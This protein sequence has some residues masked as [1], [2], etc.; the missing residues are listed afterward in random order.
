MNVSGSA[1]ATAEILTLLQIVVLMT[2]WIDSAKSR[3]G[4]WPAAG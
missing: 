1:A 3:E 4:G 2:C